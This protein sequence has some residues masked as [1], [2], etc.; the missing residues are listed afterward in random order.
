MNFLSIPE[1]NFCINCG[2]KKELNLIGNFEILCLN[3][4]NDYFGTNNSSKMLPSKYSLLL[5]NANESPLKWKRARMKDNL[6]QLVQVLN[7]LNYFYVTDQ[8]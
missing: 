5:T 6:I 8:Q 1:L 3:C 2:L 4:K 7:N